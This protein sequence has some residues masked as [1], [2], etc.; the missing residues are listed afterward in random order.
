METGGNRDDFWKSTL[1][2]I[3]FDLDV[4][5]ARLERDERLR[6][7][8]AWHIGGFADGKLKFPTFN[9]FVRPTTEA[10]PRRAPARQ[11]P[12]A[13]IAALKAIMDRRRGKG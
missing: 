8:H 10:A 11:S 2:E 12:E 6:R 13:Q 9:E 1:R 4:A 3:A 7:W 5:A